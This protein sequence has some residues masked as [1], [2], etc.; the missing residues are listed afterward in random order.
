MLTARIKV[1]PDQPNPFSWC[2]EHIG[3]VF[4]C[5]WFASWGC[6]RIKDWDG[7]WDCTFR[8]G[9]QAFEILE[10]SETPD[11]APYEAKV[12]ETT[13][14]HA[15]ALELVEKSGKML[16]YPCTTN[17]ITGR[18]SLRVGAA[19]S[20]ERAVSHLKAS[21]SGQWHAGTALPQPVTHPHFDCN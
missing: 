19:M 7:R 4:D 8:E 21:Y 9:Y 12:C 2:Y 20:N 6:W 13:H 15:T 1:L 18:I 11:C 14:T 5:Y 10:Q 16:F 17:P 3:T